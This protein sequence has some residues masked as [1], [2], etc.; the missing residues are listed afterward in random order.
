MSDSRWTYSLLSALAAFAVGCEDGATATGPQTVVETGYLS[1]AADAAACPGAA[2]CSKSGGAFEC[3]QPTSGCTPAVSCA[4]LPKACSATQV[5][6]DGAG[7]KSV[8]CQA[9]KPLDSDGDGFADAYD[10]APDDAAIFPGASEVCDGVDND[11][12]G[13]VDEGCEVACPATFPDF[14]DACTQDA[15]CVVAFHQ[16]DCCGNSAAW[17]IATGEKAGFDAAE[18]ICKGQ[19]PACGCP[20]MAPVADD[21]GR[22]WNLADYVATCSAGACVTKVSPDADA[23][24]DGTPDKDD[25][26]PYD[27]AIHPGATEICDGQDNDCDGQTDEG[28][29]TAVACGT[30][31]GAFP[32][33]DDTCAADGDCVV[34]FHQ[35]N[36]CGTQAAWGIRASEK[37]AFDAAEAICVDQYPKCGCATFPTTADDGSTSTDPNAFV[38]TC[39]AGV[40]TTSVSE[41]DSDGD[42]TPDTM[43]CAPKDATIHPGA[44]ELCNGVDENCD[45]T[46]DEGCTGVMC[47]GVTPTAFPTFDKACTAA[48]DCALVFHRINCCGSK[49]AWGVNTAVLGDFEAAEAVCRNQYPPCKCA[50]FAPVAD[51]GGSSWDTAAFAVDC[52]A[53]QCRTS[54]TAPDSDGDGTPDD[55]D[56]APLDGS[57]H[58][59]AA[60]LCDGQ[61]NDCD[62]EVDEGCSGVMCTGVQPTSFPAFDDTCAAD[63]DCAL[64]FHQ[65][66]CCGN[67]HA[68]GISASE[69]KAFA[70]AEAICQAQYPGCGCPAHTPVADDGG[71]S[72]DMT[73][74]SVACVAGQCRTS[75]AGSDTDA[76]GTPDDAD[77]AP[78]DPMIHPGAKE[79]CN[80]LD[81]NCDGT[82]DEGCTGVMCS[83]TGAGTFPE[84]D[85]AC[86]A[87][88][89]CVLVL[90]QINCC[91]STHAWGI[92]T[93]ALAA[94][95]A[96]EA[97]CESQY[98]PC[99]CAAFPPVADD[100]GSSWDM[101]GYK[102]ACV[103]GACWTSVP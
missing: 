57:I 20:A 30:S 39:E 5:C 6:V 53:G 100:G 54:V 60:E 59:G 90:H 15:D 9:A 49:E 44:V 101:N 28:C 51:D 24:A 79:I 89:D 81:D 18:T 13:E 47:T 12:D 27:P 65:T 8:T 74:F 32:T 77:C 41:P 103:G 102:V 75:V 45:G 98:P 36:C 67:T 91:G 85:D 63:T 94:F 62:G 1:C 83:G 58:P 78:N 19:Y 26:A 88:A 70:E 99:D 7:G 64:V 3:V 31:P 21:G 93:T 29:G 34:A 16:T 37:P 35:I 23:D 87:D 86:A 80:G 11:C 56:C 42:G 95:Q 92:A 14:D 68:D 22:S 96:A 69:Q 84:F 40:C 17:G 25:C 33:F 52:V 46:V 50:E 76:D 73:A 2:K 72:W 38:A 43:D 97:I 66:D 55:A 82:V 4:C 61:D 10:C 71:T 48:A